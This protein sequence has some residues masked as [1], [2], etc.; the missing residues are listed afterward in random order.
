MRLNKQRKTNSNISSTLPKNHH[1]PHEQHQHKET[2]LGKELSPK[3]KKIFFIITGTLYFLAAIYFLIE[4]FKPTLLFPNSPGLFAD[5]IIRNIDNGALP[6]PE[7]IDY[8]PLPNI[9]DFTGKPTFTK[10][11]SSFDKELK[12]ASRKYKVD[13][14]Y[15]KAHMM[16]E[17]K[18]NPNAGSS[19]GAMGLLQ[20]MPGTARML[21]Y[22]GD[23]HD[24]LIS[25]MAGAKYI[26][27]LEDTA[28][29]EQ[30]RNEVCDTAL[31]VKYQIAAYN[32]GPRCNKPAYI[33]SCD[34]QTMWQ[35]S[36]FDGYSETRHH[37]NKVKANYRWLLLNGWGC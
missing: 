26:A 28:C 15:L 27:S 29:N 3:T 36:W 10:N 2:I 11:V 31:D 19:V 12:K 13:C 8:L 21:G 14:T 4:I 1:L 25:A 33:T 6:A 5:G 23:L 18:G 16:T 37:V 17:S 24:P 7:I 22:P 32:G 20:L 30:P 35:C 9:D 34:K